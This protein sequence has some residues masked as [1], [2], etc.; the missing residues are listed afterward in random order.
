MFCQFHGLPALCV[1]VAAASGASA[2]SEETHH[3]IVG[4]CILWNLS[5]FIDFRVPQVVLAQ[6]D[7]DGDGDGGN[8]DDE[9]TTAMP[10]S[11][12]QAN[13]RRSQISRSGD[14]RSL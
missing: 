8:G 5:I 2:T 13:T 7:T 12:Q 10:Y 3:C 11:H 14:T 4:A 6:N 1:C 9:P